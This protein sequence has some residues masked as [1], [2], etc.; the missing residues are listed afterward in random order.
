MIGSTMRHANGR[1]NYIMFLRRHLQRFPYRA[2]IV[3]Q[4]TE[5]IDPRQR[6]HSRCHISVGIVNLP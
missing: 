5:V 2:R 4:M 3:A 1:Q 6:R